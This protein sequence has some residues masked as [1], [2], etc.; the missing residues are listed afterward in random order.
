MSVF[1]VVQSMDDEEWN[2]SEND[3]VYL[4]VIQA[5]MVQQMKPL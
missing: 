4:K 5:F 2:D 3:S 1:F